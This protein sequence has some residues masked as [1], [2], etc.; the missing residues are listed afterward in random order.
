M[1]NKLDNLQSKIG[2]LDK[3]LNNSDY[4]SSI[5]S[6]NKTRNNLFTKRIKN[7]RSKS[8]NSSRSNSKIRSYSEKSDRKYN[9]IY[10]PQNDIFKERYQKLLNEFN[11]DKSDLIKLRQK[12]NNLKNNLGRLKKKEQLYDDLFE[13]NNK[14]INNNELLF[15]KLEESEEV[16]MEQERLIVS[17]KK[18]VDRLRDIFN[19]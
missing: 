18:E 2:G 12:T 17:L 6:F 19:Q 8:K 11:K 10:S 5:A 9:N 16:R 15:Y 1:K 3:R 13:E 7:K 14:I 4:A